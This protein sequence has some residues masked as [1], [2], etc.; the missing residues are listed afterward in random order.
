MRLEDMSKS[1]L[2]ERCRNLEDMNT[3]LTIEKQLLHMQLGEYVEK[4]HCN[5]CEKL[6]KIHQ[7]MSGMICKIC[8]HSIIT[9]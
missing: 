6:V 7:T 4:F 8:K 2:V 3:V 9:I 5:H 1:D